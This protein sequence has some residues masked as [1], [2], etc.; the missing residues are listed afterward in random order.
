MLTSLALGAT[1][2]EVAWR[3]CVAFAAPRL[4]VAPADVRGY[5]TADESVDETVLAHLRL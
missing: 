1:S 5:W 3:A 4:G 2:A